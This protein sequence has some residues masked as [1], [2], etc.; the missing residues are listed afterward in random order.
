ML[1]YWRE[2]VSNKADNFAEREVEE[3]LKDKFVRMCD[4]TLGIFLAERENPNMDELSSSALR[5]AL[6]F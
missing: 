3:W 1:E 4:L 5:M 6:S 2:V